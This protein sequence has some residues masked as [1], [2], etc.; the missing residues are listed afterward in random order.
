MLVP[1]VACVL[2]V[3]AAD[4]EA[5][6]FQPLLEHVAAQGGH[7][8]FN[9]EEVARVFHACVDSIATDKADAIA[10]FVGMDND[11][12]YWIGCYLTERDYLHGHKAMPHVALA[13]WANASERLEAKER[14]NSEDQLTQRDLNELAAILAKRLRFDA[15]AAT[16]KRRSELARLKHTGGPAT[17]AE[18][19]RVYDS[20]TIE[21]N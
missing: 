15:L 11:R 1:I 19:Q 7:W 8:A 6:A 9:N 10:K 17:S 12:A 3:G 18:D 16:F 4:A 21:S 2:L 20:I 14:A 5:T 13:I